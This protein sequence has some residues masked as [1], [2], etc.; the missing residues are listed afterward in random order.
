M[1]PCFATNPIQIY[2]YFLTFY[3]TFICLDEVKKEQATYKA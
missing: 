1:S 3:I 2:L